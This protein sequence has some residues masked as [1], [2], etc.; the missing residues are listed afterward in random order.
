MVEGPEDGH[1]PL[2]RARGGADKGSVGPQRQGSA[3][4]VFETLRGEIESRVLPAGAVLF[5]GEIARRLSIS[6]TPVREA[7]AHLRA[8]GLVTKRPGASA[9]VRRYSLAELKE[10][11]EIRI[12]LERLA[13]ELAAQLRSEAGLAELQRREAELHMVESGLRWSALHDRFHLDLYRQSQRSQLIELIIVLRARSEPYIRMAV[14]IDQ[15]LRRTSDADHAAMAELLASGDSER[16][17]DL[18]RVHLQRTLEC[19]PR[20]LGLE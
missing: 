3:A 20:A 2:P 6:R 18:T 14:Q 15:D 12:P 17:S 13:A 10:I 4:Y 1:R 8:V 7:L 19:A 9:V 11:Y 5:E 16:L